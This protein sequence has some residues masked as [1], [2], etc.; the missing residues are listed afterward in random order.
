MKSSSKSA[1]PIGLSLAAVVALAT[2]C[3]S[4]EDEAVEG[5]RP[6]PGLPP[7]TVVVPLPESDGEAETVAIPNAVGSLEAKLLGEG[8]EVIL[9]VNGGPGLG[10]SLVQRLHEG[11]AEQLPGRR[12]FRYDPRGLGGST[13]TTSEQNT[14]AGN[15]EDIESIRQFLGVER[16]HLV[17]QS[18]GGFVS[19]AY[20][21]TRPENVASLAFID[22]SP[23]L[24]ADSDFN[25]RSN[26]AMDS[27]YQALIDAGIL[28]EGR[29]DDPPGVAW[30][31]S[32][33]MFLADPHVVPVE[34][35][36]PPLEVDFAINDDVYV[37]YETNGA[38][39]VEDVGL[40]RLPV[41]VLGGGSS[42]FGPDSANGAVAALEQ[43]DPTLV[44]IEG[45]GHFTWFEKP[46]E[47]LGAFEAFFDRVAPRN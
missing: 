39:L 36:A 40:L 20:A 26:E 7:G 44:M 24:P 34:M 37:D 16:L 30:N 38:Q 19:G 6:V 33:G 3:G 27:H 22:P 31:R 35:T 9:I 18:F 21:S 14:I 15:V 23:P 47:T 2:A 11:M 42:G 41:L 25:T 43:A 29:D 10:S 28:E 5:L 13:P 17:G 32:V 8:D 12:V 4:S 45:A 1:A 46:E